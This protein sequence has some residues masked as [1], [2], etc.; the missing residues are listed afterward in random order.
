MDEN[1]QDLINCYQNCL[2]LAKEN[3]CRTIVNKIM[4]LKAQVLIIN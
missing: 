2:E 3:N 1:E 4:E